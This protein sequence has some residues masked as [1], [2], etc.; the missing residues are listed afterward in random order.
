MQ[1]QHGADL[2]P[3]SW[4]FSAAQDFISK[5]TSWSIMAEGVAGA[6]RWGPRG[7]EL[8]LSTL[9][10]FLEMPFSTSLART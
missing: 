6:G 8:T 10:A 7:K 4:L 2:R 1:G 3:G 9:R 5:V